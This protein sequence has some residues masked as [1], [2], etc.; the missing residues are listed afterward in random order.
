MKVLRF[1]TSVTVTSSAPQRV[2]Y[3]TVTDLKAHLL[4]SGERARDDGFKR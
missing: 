1:Q 2:G 3:E 4:W